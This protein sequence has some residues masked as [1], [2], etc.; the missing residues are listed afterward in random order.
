MD[1]RFNTARTEAVSDAVLAIA[2]TLLVLDLSVPRSAF[3]RLGSA[4]GGLWGSYLPT[5]PASGRSGGCGWSTRPLFR[6][7]RYLDGALIRLNLAASMAVALQTCR[8]HSARQGPT[9]LSPLAHLALRHPC[10][11]AVSFRGSPDA[12]GQCV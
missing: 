1:E 10:F 9:S 4:I 8:P 12:A 5:P 7:M 2:I 11:S 3:D 6:R